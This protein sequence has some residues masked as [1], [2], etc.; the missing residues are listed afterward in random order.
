MEEEAISA[1]NLAISTTN[2]AISNQTL[3]NLIKTISEE[4]AGKCRQAIQRDNLQAV[5]EAAISRTNPP[6]QRPGQ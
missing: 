5:R 4:K 2:L 1:I 6:A 3:T